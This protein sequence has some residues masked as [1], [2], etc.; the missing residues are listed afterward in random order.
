MAKATVPQPNFQTP[1]ADYGKVEKIKMGSNGVRGTLAE[2]FRD[3]SADDIMAEAEQIAKSHG[4]YLEYNRAKSGREKDWMFMVRISVPGGGPFSGEKWAILDDVSE[5]VTAGPDFPPSMRITTRQNIQFHWVKKKHILELVSTVAKTGF[6][7]MNGC[8]DNAR[9]V[10][11]CPL[12]RFSDVLDTHALAHKTAG[13]F[14]VAPEAHVQIFA[15]DPGYMRSPDKRFAYGPALLNRKFKIAFA[16]VHRDEQTGELFRDNCVEALTNDVGVVPVIDGDKV[17]RVQLFVGGGQGEKNGKPTFAG[18]GRPIGIIGV[19]DV[20][21][22]LDAV[23]TIHNE[24]GDRQNRHWARVKY[25]MHEMGPQWWTDQV[26][27]RGIKLADA[28]PAVQPGPRRLHHGW[29]RQ[30]SNGLWAYGAWIENG[31]LQDNERGRYKSMVRHVMDKYDGIEVSTTPNQDLLFSNLPEDAKEQ[32]VNDL[33][34]FGYKREGAAGRSTLRTLSGACVGLYTCRLSYTES[35]QFEPELLNA[36]EQRGYGDLSESIG[37]TGC[38]RQ[39]FRPSTKTIGWIGQG[40]D[41]YS[42]RLGGSADGAHQGVFLVGKA[43]GNVDEERWFL[44]QV[45]RDKVADVCAALFD[46]WAD[47]REEGEDAGR[48]FRRLGQQGVIDYLF[49]HADVAPLM[50]KTYAAPFTPDYQRF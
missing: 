5:K 48:C 8:G 1:Q 39:C 27:D 10:M 21:P 7:T 18:L 16:A 24:W 45:P 30:P 32:F 9:N 25:V 44:R 33:A 37:I 19:E 42:L 36:L 47:R 28:D 2:E 17:E 46:L 40:P 26:R 15:I 6:F 35:E 34:E 50:E 4:I 20:I 29:T 12:G 49:A 11:G 43:P 23:A 38:E 14:Q 13:F 31:R 41:L 22:A 3:L